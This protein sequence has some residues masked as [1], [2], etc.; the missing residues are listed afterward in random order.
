MRLRLFSNG[1]CAAPILATE[2]NFLEG[3]VTKVNTSTRQQ[4][5]L[6]A[7]GLA[8]KA[9]L[10]ILATGLNEKLNGELGVTRNIIRRA[11]SFCIGFCVAPENGT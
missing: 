9:R 1:E 10:V 3:H 8:I 11:Q 5:V 6:L 2:R 7:D 4:W